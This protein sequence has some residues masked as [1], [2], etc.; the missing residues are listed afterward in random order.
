MKNV[1]KNISFL[2]LLYFV[3]KMKEQSKQT[4]LRI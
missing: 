3:Q 2:I 1:K 4:G